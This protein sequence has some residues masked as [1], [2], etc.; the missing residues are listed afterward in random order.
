RLDLFMTLGKT[1]FGNTFRIAARNF[2]D[3]SYDFSAGVTFS[4][5][6]GNR[7]DEAR[8][9]AARATRQQ[10]AASIDNLRRLITLDVQVAA[11]EV[12][13][14]R[15]QI[16][17]PAATRQLREEALRAE[18]ERFRVGSSTSLLV[19]QAQRDLVASQ[20]DEIEAVIGYRVALIN[21]HLAEGTLLEL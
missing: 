7:A 21:L 17:A 2:E 20:I 1:G 19:A 13:R 6:L 14:S 11:A 10:A 16:A 4:H 5:F 18:Q 8:D 15:Q 3:D 9:L 12:E